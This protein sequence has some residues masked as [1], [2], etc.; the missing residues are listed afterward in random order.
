M[1]SD[2]LQKRVRR[3]ARRLGGQALA[4]AEADARRERARLRDAIEAIPEGVVFLDAQGRYILWNQ[5]YAEIY[6]RSADLFRPG[7]KL[8]DTLRIG[9]ERGD[10]PEAIGREGEWLA[11]RLG[12]LSSPT[13]ER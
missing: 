10:Y 6:H 2:G 13:G 12:K 5:R 9:V 11:Q 1:G 4:E 8:E 7:A 3:I